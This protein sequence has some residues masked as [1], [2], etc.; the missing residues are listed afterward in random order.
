M[1]TYVIPGDTQ[2]ANAGDATGDLNK[3]YDMLGLICRLMAQLHTGTGSAGPACNAA[4][5]T[6]LQSLISGAADL[7][8]MTTLGDLVYEDATPKPARRPR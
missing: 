6:A 3:T 7:G 8:G 1:P 5:V 4:N 2:V